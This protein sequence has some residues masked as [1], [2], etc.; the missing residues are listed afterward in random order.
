M[1]TIDIA[2]TYATSLAGILLLTLRRFF[3][4]LHMFTLSH[5]L[6]YIILAITRRMP[7]YCY[8]TLHCC[9]RYLRFY[10]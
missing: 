8:D 5:T 9:R 4:T 2:I 7:G 1:L 3:H 10:S 6:I